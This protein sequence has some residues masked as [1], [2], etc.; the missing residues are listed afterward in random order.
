MSELINK[1][2]LS[3][4]L[5]GGAGT[6]LFPLTKDRSKPA[7]P[8]AGKFRLIDIPISNC[9]NSGIRRMFVLTQYN[10]RSLN[11]HIKNSYN[12]DKFTNSFVDILAAEQTRY[13]K[14]WFQGTADAVRKSVPHVRAQDYKNILLLSGDQLYQMDYREIISYHNSQDADITVA[15]IPVVAH[16]ATA[17][18]IMKTREDG[19]IESFV[20]KPPLDELER[21]K[22]PLPEEYTR[23]EKHYQA[24][25][26]IYVFSKGVLSKLFADMPEAIDFGKELIPHAVTDS[27]YKAVSFP[28]GGYWTDIGNIPSYFEA[29]LLLAANMP[30]FNMYDNENPIFSNARMLSPS[31]IINTR[32]DGALVASG[33]II[34]A[35]H[36]SN[37]VIGIRSRI[38]ENTVIENTYVM[39]IDY[40]Q[41]KLGLDEQRANQLL[42]IGNNCH[43]RNAIIDKN[44]K[45]GNNSRITGHGDLADGDYDGYSVRQ[46][47]VIVTKNAVMPEGTVI[48]G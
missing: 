32:L 1:E 7:V 10:S 48:G 3:I 45:I 19:S 47:I 35:R 42:G 13:H 27:R 11:R 9:L 31:K 24:S 16:E 43:I 40:Y 30:P 37:S 6:R 44:V 18:G 4:I 8:L 23:Q 17:F 22:S 14:D 26:G 12:F 25:M 15:T 46:G 39:G 5:G 33:C 29:N 21:W 34:N 38:G 20:E 2:T 41:T 28:F 36:I